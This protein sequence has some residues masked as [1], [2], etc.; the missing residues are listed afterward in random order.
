LE[1]K[2]NLPEETVGKNGPGNRFTK[3]SRPNRRPPP[4]QEKK[5]GKKGKDGQ[6]K[7]PEA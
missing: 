2:G 6:Q 5:R 4:D 7:G 1:G 3:I